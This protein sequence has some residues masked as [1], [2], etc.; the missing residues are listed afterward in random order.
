IGLTRDFPPL[1]RAFLTA[2]FAVGI[3]WL[4]GDA[5]DLRFPWYTAP[6]ALG[7]APWCIAWVRWMGCYGLSYFIWLVA[8]WGAF[9][10]PLAWGGFLLLPIG[11]LLLPTFAPPDRHALLLQAERKG[12]LEA[13]IARTDAET[14]VDLAVLPEYSY[15][16]DY[17][18]VLASSQGPQIL[19][20][21]FHCPVIFGAIDGDLKSEFQ[22]VAVVLATDGGWLGNF[23]KQRPVPLLRDGLPGTVRPV[24]PLD[25]G[26]LGLAVCYDFDAP[27]V[28][29]SLVEQGATVLVAPN[30][31]ALTW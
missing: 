24:F 6:H 31:D 12:A 23:P 15:F 27:P 13:V 10:P 29:A 3:E 8:A 16:A 1:V 14:P 26:T 30:Y 4:R 21:K 5:W 22:N 9:G 2:L 25:Q 7:Q 17:R 20:H 19:A 18:T 28:V 11:C